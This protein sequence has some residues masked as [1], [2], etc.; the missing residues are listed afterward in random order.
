MG[1]F[2]PTTGKASSPNEDTG[3]YGEEAKLLQNNGTKTLND[4]VYKPGPE[5][6]RQCLQKGEA[7]FLTL[8]W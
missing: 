4:R 8:W 7:L 6:T 2:N 5:S 1:D 3:Q